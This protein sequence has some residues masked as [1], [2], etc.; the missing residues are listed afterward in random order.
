MIL[1][2]KQSKGINNSIYDHGI[3]KSFTLVQG[4]FNILPPISTKT[5]LLMLSRVVSTVSI[6]VRFEDILPWF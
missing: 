3:G 4:N 1:F 2:S 5:P 6:F